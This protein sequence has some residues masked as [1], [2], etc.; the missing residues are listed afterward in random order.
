MRKG[1]PQIVICMSVHVKVCETLLLL[2][3]EKPQTQIIDY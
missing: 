3:R 1:I 2:L